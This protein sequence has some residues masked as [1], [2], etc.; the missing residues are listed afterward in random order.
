MEQVVNVSNFAFTSGPHDAKVMLI[1]ECWGSQEAASRRPFVGASGHELDKMLHESGLPRSTVL[2]TNVIDAQPARNDFTNFLYSN[3]EIKALRK[4]KREVREYFGT[5]PR[6]LLQRGITKLWKLID[7]VKPDLILSAGNWPLHILSDHATVKTAKGFKLPGG[8]TSWRGSQTYSRVSP[9]GHTYR[10]LPIVHPAAILRN[11]SLRNVTVHDLRSRA[12]RYLDGTLSWTPPPDLTIIR[13]KFDDIERSFNLWLARA[14]TGELWLSVDLETYQKKYISVLGIAD[15]TVSL[16]LPF[17]SFGKNQ[18]LEDYW[19]YEQEIEIW[20]RCRALLEHP[21][22]RII[23]QNFVYDTQFFDRHYDIKAMVSFDTMVGH[24]LLFPGTSKGL[25]NLASLYCHHYRYWKDESQD[26]N[27][28]P[29]NLDQYWRYNCKDTRATYES[30][31]TLR[32]LISR[33][34]GFFEEEACA[35]TNDWRSAGGMWEQYQDK[36]D[37]WELAREMTRKGIATDAAS[38]AEISMELFHL[39]NSLEQFLLLCVPDAFKHN[40]KGGVWASSAQATMRLLYDIIGISP[41]LHK[42]TK[43]PTSDDIAIN[44]L[45]ER[46]ELS[47]LEPLLGSLLAYRSV[48]VFR[49]NFIDIKLGVSGRIHSQFNISHPKTHRWSSTKTAFGEGTN[50]QNTPKVE[51]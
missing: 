28:G 14:S 15:E 40:A 5:Y 35:L 20:R 43:R 2:C 34:D 19:T 41:I 46:P 48:G 22:I 33:A 13:P 44:N 29:E 37:Q 25:H 3:D 21:N 12:K 6:E 51:D 32:T 23:G 38:R 42:K 26:W 49:K 9:A 4:E 39:A 50:L 36:L 47:W 8:I 11:W 1:G 17:F 16:C 18:R 45:L 10:L 24:H 31:Q 27:E 30:A 7:E